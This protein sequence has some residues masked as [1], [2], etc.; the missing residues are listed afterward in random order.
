MAPTFTGP[1]QNG[2]S[3]PTFSDEIKAFIVIGLDCF[4][5]PRKWWRP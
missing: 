4:D 2:E 3:A 1:L 5:S